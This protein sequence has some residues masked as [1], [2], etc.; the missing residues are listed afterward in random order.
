FTREEIDEFKPLYPGDRAP[1][2][3]DYPEIYRALGLFR[4]VSSTSSNESSRSSNGSFGVLASL[5]DAPG[6]GS[7]NWVISGAR[8][9]TG[10]PLLANDPHLGLTTPS[11][12]YVARLRAPDFEVFGATL[13][14]VPYV[15]LGRTRQVAWGFTNTGPDVQDL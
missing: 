2:L 4:P 9:T 5:D 12:W 1:A 15:L 10:K 11:V 3:A 7:N 14:G 8:T 13:P 6:I